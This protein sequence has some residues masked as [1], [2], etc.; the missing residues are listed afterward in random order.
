MYALQDVESRKF[1]GLFMH[2]PKTAGTFIRSYI[3][4]AYSGKV[5][6]RNPHHF[7]PTYADERIKQNPYYQSILDHPNLPIDDYAHL[8][9]EQAFKVF[10]T[11]KEWIAD[12]DIDVFTV[13]RNPYDR[14]VSVMRFIPVMMNLDMDI[15]GVPKFRGQLKPHEFHALYTNLL[16][17]PQAEW[18]MHEGEQI[19]RIIK[20]EDVTDTIVSLTGDLKV[21][22]R[23][24]WW[25]N[26]DASK[27]LQLDFNIPKFDLDIETRKFVEW[28]WKDDFDLGL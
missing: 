12:H 28:L 16:T 20:L 11:L 1:F 17:L 22:F 10:P 13:T 9:L 21:D 5:E 6:I 3:H 26:E 24:R 15:K 14:F 19:S 27:A 23:D 8:T 18:I 4:E 25:T 7:L 2:I